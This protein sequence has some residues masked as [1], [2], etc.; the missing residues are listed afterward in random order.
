MSA[1]V[2]IRVGYVYGLESEADLLRGL[3][4]IVYPIKCKTQLYN[5]SPGDFNDFIRL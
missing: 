3:Y 1:P 2:G 4:F 5:L